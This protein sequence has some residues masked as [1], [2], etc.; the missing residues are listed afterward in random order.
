MF[1]G[2]LAKILG[3]A[4]VL[5][6]LAGGISSG[7]LYV[8]KTR[9]ERRADSERQLKEAAESKLAAAEKT[10]KL[11]RAWEAIDEVIENTDDDVIIDYLRTG[12]WPQDRDKTGD[13]PAPVPG[14]APPGKPPKG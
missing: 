2:L 13:R 1:S 10:I 11:L 4:L 5:S 9:A 14:P 6:L 12:V 7:I 3:G 8:Q